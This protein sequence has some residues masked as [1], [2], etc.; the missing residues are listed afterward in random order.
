MFSSAIEQKSDRDYTFCRDSG[1]FLWRTIAILGGNTLRQL[2]DRD[3][4]RRNRQT[5]ALSHA[6]RCMIVFYFPS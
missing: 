5:T 3:P 6:L 1:L 4:S 2:A